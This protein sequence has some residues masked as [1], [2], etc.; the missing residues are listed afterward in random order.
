MGCTSSKAVDATAIQ[1]YRPPPSSF[2]V[3]DIN[4]IQE[5]WLAF[6]ISAQE[7]QEKPNHV[8]AP[9]LEKLNKLES[10]TPHSWDEVSKVLE[11][12]KP[13]LHNKNN[14]LALPAP[15]LKAD[16]I[17][18][19]AKDS[20]AEKKQTLKK[21]ASFHTLEELDTKLSS[22]EPEPKNHF[23]K[24]TES[25]SPVVV[26]PQT[27]S[28]KVIKPL[29]DNIFILRDKQEKEKEGKLANYDKIRRFDPLSDYPEKIPPNGGADSVVIYTTTLGGVRKTFDD[30]N[31]VRSLLEGHTVL[32]DERDVALHGGFLNELRE[33]LGE[34]VSLPRVFVKGRYIGGVD[35]V[36]ELN[37]LGK[38]GRILNWARVERGIGRQACEGCGGARFVPCLDCGGSCKVVVDGVKERCGKCNENGLA[39]CP[40][41]L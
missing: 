29:K 6:D 5:P 40:L 27:N 1:V 37:E 26:E 25:S 23:R 7:N 24:T 12:L 35:H 2:A 16:A 21:N 22:K 41:C 36:V 3:F 20:S 32:F 15:P 38:L 19:P 14:L 30:C 33:L 31:R 39:L 8:P 17:K 11:D 28:G 10:D 4:S 9:L 18:P 34:E 13:T